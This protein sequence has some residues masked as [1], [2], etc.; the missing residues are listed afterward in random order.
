MITRIK[1]TKTQLQSLNGVMTECANHLDKGRPALVIAQ[2][3]KDG[4]TFAQTLA[5]NVAVSVIAAKAGLLSADRQLAKG[6]LD[7]WK[8][9]AKNANRDQ[10]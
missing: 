7:E 1:L 3:Q 2:I 5:D 10:K 6:I 8:A 4:T 9:K